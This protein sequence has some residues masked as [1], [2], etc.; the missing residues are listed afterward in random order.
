VSIDADQTVRD[1]GEQWTHYGDN[2][3]YYASVELLQDMMGPLATLDELRDARVADIGSGTGRIVRMLLDAGAAH[4]TAVEPSVG[5]A[6]LRE[7]TRDVADRVEI[8]HAQGDALPPGRDF[9]WVF[10]IGVIQF[11]PDPQPVLRAALNALRPG[12]RC[13]IW[14]YGREGNGLYLAVLGALRS[15]TTRLPHRALAALCTVL[16]W[17]LSLYIG[18]CRWLPLPL[19]DYARGTLARLSSAERRLTIYDQLNPTYVHY[20]SEEE[21]RAL[22]ETA[23]FERVELHHRRGYSWTVMGVR[24]ASAGQGVESSNNG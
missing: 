23:G 10:S 18:L 7:N 6:Q 14:V 16:D 17:G 4:V 11:I 24:G 22:L 5:V 15:V 21:A 20:H 3:G 8:L 9:D 19:R 2:A 12:G 13:L 1:F